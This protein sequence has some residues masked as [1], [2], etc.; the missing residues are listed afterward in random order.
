MSLFPYLLLPDGIADQAAALGHGMPPN[1]DDARFINA[2]PE[3]E[4]VEATLSQV[5]NADD[6]EF[7]RNVPLRVCRGVRLPLKAPSGAENPE[8][9]RLYGIVAEPRDEVDFQLVK[10]CALVAAAWPRSRRWHDYAY[11]KPP[12][13]KGTE[14][15]NRIWQEALRYRGGWRE[16]LREEATVNLFSQQH[17]LWKAA[18]FDPNLADENIAP[19]REYSLPRPKKRK[20]QKEQSDI[21]PSIYWGL[22]HDL[23]ECTRVLKSK[24]QSPQLD[25]LKV[26]TIEG[27][28][29][30]KYLKGHPTLDPRSN[31]WENPKTGE[32]HFHETV[33]E[34]LRNTE[35]T[36]QFMNHAI[37]VALAG[38]E[39]LDEFP[40]F[41]VQNGQPR[42]LVATQVQWIYVE[43]MLNAH[44]RAV[45]VQ[46]GVKPPL[47]T[48]PP[49]NP[50]PKEVDQSAALASAVQEWV[51]FYT[52]QSDRA[53]KLALAEALQ[54]LE[55]PAP[56]E[57][58]ATGTD[59]IDPNSP[60][61][62][63]D[64]PA[65][66]DA[67]LQIVTLARLGVT[68][69]R[70]PMFLNELAGDGEPQ[71]RLVVEYALAQLRTIRQ[72]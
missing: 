53:R 41:S 65:V 9:F 1:L 16:Y 54:T 6:V 13:D 38:P 29:F 49:T 7:V 23:A 42:R 64:A 46:Y 71:V 70:T 28:L 3:E 72:P 67:C 12:A 25:D 21:V 4:T 47:G 57:W 31:P 48:R 68:D 33:H 44:K 24:E 14:R 10:E 60:T 56:V 15:N 22:C 36:E 5:N 19:G 18:L 17:G 37:R 45:Y 40:K 62:E 20:K 11:F 69:P 26:A 51:Q 63:P 30:K 59:F 27:F 50:E 66:I 58:E 55:F 52:P 32:Y 61:N 39:D 35:R 8:E 34:S 43:L 2:K